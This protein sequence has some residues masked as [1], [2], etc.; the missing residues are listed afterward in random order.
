MS[1]PKSRIFASN[2]AMNDLSK[3]WTIWK[4]RLVACPPFRGLGDD[5]IRDVKPGSSRARRRHACPERRVLLD[6]LAGAL[7]MWESASQTGPEDRLHQWG[8]KPARLLTI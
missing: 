7:L 3:A 5:E 4:Q 1:L 6:N 2:P 8:I